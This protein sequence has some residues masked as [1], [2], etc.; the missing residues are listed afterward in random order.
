MRK[1]LSLLAIIIIFF[2][3]L[4]LI[5]CDSIN[6]LT[7]KVSGLFF[8]E[9]LA[10]AA[11]ETVELFF[12]DVMAKDYKAAY[13]YIQKPVDKSYEDF[14]L[15]FEDVTDIISVEIN[16]VEVKNNLAE[17]GIDI[18]DSYDGDEKIYKDLVISLLRE[19]E[20]DW[21]IVFWD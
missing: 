6:D 14:Y 12:D 15:E 8:D 11:V 16:W 17:V 13:S 18:I 2:V 20:S 1:T 5:S 7:G 3:S 19:E 4:A 9:E 21:E 10:D